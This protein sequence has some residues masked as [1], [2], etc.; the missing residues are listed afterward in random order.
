MD[1]VHCTRHFVSLLT[2]LLR[3]LL[4][5]LNSPGC[6]PCPKGGDCLGANEVLAVD[7]YWRLQYQYDS[8]VEYL[9]ATQGPKC[10]QEGQ[11]CLF[12]PGNILLKFLVSSPLW[13]APMICTNLS[14]RGLVCARSQNQA[15]RRSS[16]ASFSSSFPS[17]LSAAKSSSL[18]SSSSPSSS[19]SPTASFPSNTSQPK[20]ALTAKF[21]RCYHAG[22]CA[23]GNQ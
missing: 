19:P 12:P 4:L 23:R 13:E 7:G 11:V 16:T 1:T 6:L 9:P 14:S 20:E 5:G 17:A 21:L 22:A 15:G 2:Q 18:S 10:Q 3:Y 8:V